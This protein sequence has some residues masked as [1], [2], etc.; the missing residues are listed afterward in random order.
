MKTAEAAQEN[1]FIA[2]ESWGNLVFSVVYFWIF[3]SPRP[4]RPLWC[5]FVMFE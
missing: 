1:S 5:S 3:I 4:L 2:V